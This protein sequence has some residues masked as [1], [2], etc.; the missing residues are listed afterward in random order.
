MLDQVYVSFNFTCL[1]TEH[2][3]KALR[4]YE[5]SNKD[6]DVTLQYTGGTHKLMTY[7]LDL[8]TRGMNCFYRPQRG[9]NLGEK[10]QLAISDSF[11]RGHES[12][13][14]IGNLYFLRYR[15]EH[16]FHL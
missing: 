4:R 10:L 16:G 3:L 14:V 7:W 6:V 1:Q 12:V 2:I 8:K 9:N 15:Y 5:V 13:V 11:N